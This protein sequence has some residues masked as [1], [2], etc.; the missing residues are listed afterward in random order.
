MA[1]NCQS[2]YAY[3]S[4]DTIEAV[5]QLSSKYEFTILSETRETM[6]RKAT[7]DHRFL[8][9]HEYFSTYIDQFKGGVGILVKKVFEK[10]PKHRLK[11]MLESHRARARWET[12]AFGAAGEL[13]NLRYIF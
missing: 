7:L 8:C 4:I 5:E 10:N 6:E 1:F 13:A 12:G 11:D 2:L 9:Q 3:D